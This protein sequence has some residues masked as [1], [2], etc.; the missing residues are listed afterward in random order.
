MYSLFC[1]CL[2]KVLPEVCSGKIT[3]TV[4]VPHALG[5]YHMAPVQCLTNCCLDYCNRLKNRPLN[6]QYSSAS[7]KPAIWIIP[8]GS[9]LKHNYRHVTPA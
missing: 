3:D 5:P 1:I 6:L 2:D 8:R 7:L 9:F 4:P